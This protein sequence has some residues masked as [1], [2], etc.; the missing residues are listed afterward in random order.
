MTREDAIERL[1]HVYE[2]IHY[3]K[4]LKCTSASISKEYYNET[5]KALK[6]QRKL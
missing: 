1:T 6:W 4:V 5:L 2:L 3:A